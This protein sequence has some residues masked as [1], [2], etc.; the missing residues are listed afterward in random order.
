MIHPTEQAVEYIYKRFKQAH[1]EDELLDIAKNGKKCYEPLNTD[2]TPCNT[3][4]IAKSYCDCG[5]KSRMPN[6]VLIHP[7]Y[8]QK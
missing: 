6:R 1:F 7:S 2:R 8:W 3:R 4:N 5:R